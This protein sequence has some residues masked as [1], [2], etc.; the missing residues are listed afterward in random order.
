MGAAPDVARR[1]FDS[2]RGISALWLSIFAGPVAWAI[3]LLLSYSLVPWTCGGGPPVVLQLISVFALAII[4]AGA[5]AGWQSLAQVPKGAPSDGS[6]PDQRAYFMASLGLV[7][8]A[9]FAVI[10]VAGAVPRWI[11]DACHQ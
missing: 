5:F 3:D 1:T 4:G 10:V 7:M 11:L 9:L 6:Q 2:P 8:C